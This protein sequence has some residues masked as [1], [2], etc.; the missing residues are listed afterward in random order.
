MAQRK[1]SVASVFA[2][3]AGLL[4]AAP[5]AAQ[6][7][8]NYVDVQLVLAVDISYSMDPEEQA[9]Q[10][11]GYADA[12]VSREFLDALRLGP[13]GRIALS[14]VEWAGEQEQ[15]LVIGWQI[16]DGPDSAKA[17]S[18]AVRAT[19]LRRAYRTSISGALKFSA[20]LFKTS[21]Y[22]GLRNVID[23]SGD[24]VNNQGPPVTRVRDDLVT[25]GITI[26][27]LPLLLK[28]STNAAMDVPELDLYYE[29]CVIGGPGAFVIPVR[30][31]SEFARAIKTKLVLE[32]A[33]VRPQPAPSRIIPAAEPPRVSC[34]I[35][36]RMWQEHWNN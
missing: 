35:G 10:R 29:D 8:D 28:R 27:G 17:F 9:L 30:A 5:A 25:R 11:D 36:E 34:L 13:R 21:G 7:V 20:D 23:V 15:R 32:V 18:D 16:V 24:G 3:L 14:Y 12:L 22:R 19:P 2:V 1:F 4:C 26:N 6:K 33:G 31:P